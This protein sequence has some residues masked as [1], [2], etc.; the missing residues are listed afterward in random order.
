MATTYGPGKVDLLSSLQ[1][2]MDCEYV[3]AVRY[4]MVAT[5]DYFQSD[6]DVISYSMGAPISRKV[7]LFIEI[8]LTAIFR[9]S[10][11]DTV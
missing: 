10:W 8:A 2:T 5:I 3:K 6:I 7:L 1:E 11:E 4:L 9:P